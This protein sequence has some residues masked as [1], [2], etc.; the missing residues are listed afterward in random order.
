MSK[1][2][3]ISIEYENE[4]NMAEDC[5]LTYIGRDED[6]NNIYIGKSYEWNKF[7]KLREIYDK[8]NTI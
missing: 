3:N 5:G 2:K 8:T 1:M 6:N 7:E 4:I